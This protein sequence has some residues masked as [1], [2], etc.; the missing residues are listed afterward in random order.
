MFGGCRFQGDKN[1]QHQMIISFAFNLYLTPLML[2]DELQC[3][4]LQKKTAL[5]FA[6][7]INSKA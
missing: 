6:S 7:Y 1:I 3:I 5:D 2:L 4:L